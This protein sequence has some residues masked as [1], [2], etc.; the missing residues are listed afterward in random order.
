MCKTDTGKLLNRILI[1]IEHDLLLPHS[2]R[3]NAAKEIE[4]CR[5]INVVNDLGWSVASTIGL[6]NGTKIP[7]RIT[8]LTDNVR[9]SLIFPNPSN[10]NYIEIMLTVIQRLALDCN[11]TFEAILLKLLN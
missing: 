11:S 10:D 8:K 9:Q 7:Y 4:L 5:L 2:D 6:V 3:L 1:C